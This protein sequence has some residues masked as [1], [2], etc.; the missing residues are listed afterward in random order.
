MAAAP[1]PKAVKRINGTR[2]SPLS[3]PTISVY[4]LVMEAFTKGKREARVGLTSDPRLGLRL[5]EKCSLMRLTLICE[6]KQPEETLFP[7]I[8]QSFLFCPHLAYFSLLKNTFSQ[9]KIEE[10]GV[11]V[12]RRR[13]AN[14]FSNLPWRALTWVSVLAELGDS[15]GTS[16]EPFCGRSRPRAP[17]APVRPECSRKKENIPRLS[18][19]L[20]DNDQRC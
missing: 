13:H 11:T 18:L 20:R 10:D 7:L 8:T 1:L 16:F 12:R 2:S 6:R 9:W 17:W 19:V 5:R 15:P 14:C 4:S 3:G